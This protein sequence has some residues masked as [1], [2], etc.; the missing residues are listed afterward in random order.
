M[1]EIRRLR[2]VAGMT[3]AALARAAG[4]SQ[5]TVAAYEAGH[6]SPTL[7]TLHRLAESIGFTMTIEY[8]RALTREERRSLFLHRAIADRLARDP[9]RVLARARATLARMLERHPR[10]APLLDE[11]SLLLQ[12]PSAELIGLLTDSGP[13]ACELRHVTPF[14][15]I[16]SAPERASIYRAF[17]AS[18]RAA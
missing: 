2:D 17:A 8:Q 13:H 1:N 15:G 3:Q 18:E 12:Q 6:K 16:L 14:A 11:W 4:T 7:A 10:A 9:E 5:P